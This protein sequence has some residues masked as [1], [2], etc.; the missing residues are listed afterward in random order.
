MDLGV[1]RGV[2]NSLEL[3]CYEFLLMGRDVNSWESLGEVLCSAFMMELDLTSGVEYR[4]K[5]VFGDY[6]G[7]LNSM[8]IKYLSY[9]L[10]V[11]YSFKVIK[12]CVY[13][14][15]ILGQ[16]C[17]GVVFSTSRSDLICYGGNGGICFDDVFAD[18]G[19]SKVDRFLGLF[20]IVL[21]SGGSVNCELV[22]V[23]MD[24]LS[25]V[26][27]VY[28][29][30]NYYKTTISSYRS[31]SVCINGF[32]PSMSWD[33]YDILQKN[34]INVKGVKSSFGWDE[35]IPYRGVVRV[36]GDVIS[37]DQYDELPL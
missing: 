1:Y 36:D 29:G 20:N 18:C 23:D 32:E 17:Y 9:D 10:G 12:D 4:G 25:L 24:Q 35:V 22:N 30:E 11:R 26:S 2:L 15:D 19:I 27:F 37:F 31:N 8:V 34:S 21:Y 14:M 5:Y 7:V 3:E 13:H 33:R 6:L 28:G 16:G